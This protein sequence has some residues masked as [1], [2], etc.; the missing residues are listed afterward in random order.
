MPPGTP[1]YYLLLNF[2]FYI[3]L[4]LIRNSEVFF[5]ENILFTYLQGPVHIGQFLKVWF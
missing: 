5:Y 1:I 2:G 4:I 3:E